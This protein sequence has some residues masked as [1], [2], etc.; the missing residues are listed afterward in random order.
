M[1]VEA[2]LESWKSRTVDRVPGEIKNGGE[3]EAGFYIDP[4]KRHEHERTGNVDRM[5]LLP[6]ICK[7]PGSAQSI[8]MGLS[9]LL[10]N[11][12]ALARFI[13]GQRRNGGYPWSRSGGIA[14]SG[15]SSL[16][17]I[18]PVLLSCH[19]TIRV[20][21]LW[22]SSSIL[23]ARCFCFHYRGQSTLRRLWRDLSRAH[24]ESSNT[25]ILIRALLQRSRSAG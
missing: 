21:Q 12:V 22:R 11:A 4:W 9:P 14:E 17:S 15:H 19:A 7:C 18:L 24:R 6:L 2:I 25:P 5:G 20:D 3:P 1:L 13:G 8:A 16:S 10:T 23:I